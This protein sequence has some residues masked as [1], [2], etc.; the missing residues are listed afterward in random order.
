[1]TT[2]GTWL[3]IAAGVAWSMFLAWLLRRVL[4]HWRERERLELASRA[5]LAS[6]Y[7]AEIR[8]QTTTSLPLSWPRP[9]GQEDADADFANVVNLM[10]NS[11][12]PVPTEAEGRLSALKKQALG[13]NAIKR[14]DLLWALGEAAKAASPKDLG[15]LSEAAKRVVRSTPQEYKFPEYLAVID[16]MA[17]Q[18]IPVRFDKVVPLERDLVLGA[19]PV[20]QIAF[21]IPCSP[22]DAVFVVRPW[23]RPESA[24]PLGVLDQ[25]CSWRLSIWLDSEEILPERSIEEF[26]VDPEGFGYRERAFELPTTPAPALQVGCYEPPPGQANFFVSPP[27]SVVPWPG[28]FVTRD[29]W[30][31]LMLGKVRSLP[32]EIPIRAGLVAAIYTTKACV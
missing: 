30:I 25:L 21:E 15:W 3:A 6:D 16:R 19:N 27:D 5:P 23:I 28:L 12:L 14:E 4:R 24:T 32:C 9:V 20:T 1:M 18:A 29:Q 17:C 11:R 13:G 10:V 22:C 8:R 31:R 26:L 2:M 7:P